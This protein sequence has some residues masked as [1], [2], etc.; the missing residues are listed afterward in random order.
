M[1]GNVLERIIEKF[2]QVIGSN[3]SS[4]LT[5]CGNAYKTPVSPIALKFDLGEISYRASSF[6]TT[7]AL[8]VVKREALL[9]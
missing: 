6:W 1:L 3:Q 2:G 8:C 7:L 4:F 5:E 9:C